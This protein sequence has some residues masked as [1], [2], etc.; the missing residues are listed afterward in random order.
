MNAE[1]KLSKMIER[2]AEHMQKHHP[3]RLAK[4]ESELSKKQEHIIEMALSLLSHGGLD[5]ITLRKLAKEMNL[6]APAIYWH[7]KNKVTLIDYM[8]EAI[9]QKELPTIPVCNG[10]WRPWL[11]DLCLHLYRAMIKYPDGG[12]VVAGAHLGIARTL[13]DIFEHGIATLHDYGLPID[14][15]AFVVST[16]INYTFGFTIEEQASRAPDIAARDQMLATYPTIEKAMRKIMSNTP[17][18]RYLTGLSLIIPIL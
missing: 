14:Q 7:F 12:K 17:E 13:G 4:I 16:A 11:T 1:E 3:E 8:A 15:S 18:S 5:N 10:N 9:L 2:H 6:Q